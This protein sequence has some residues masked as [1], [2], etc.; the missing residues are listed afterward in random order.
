MSI[1]EKGYVA[2]TGFVYQFDV[3]G[4]GNPDT[5]FEIAAQIQ[6]SP[7]EK[8]RIRAGNLEHSVN[9]ATWSQML[10]NAYLDGRGKPERDRMYVT[11]LVERTEKGNDIR[12]VLFPAPRA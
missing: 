7:M 2:V 1:D 6:V 12:R 8:V 9:L 3:N 5:S 11:V 10:L 4:A